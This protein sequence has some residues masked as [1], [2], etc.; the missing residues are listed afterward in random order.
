MFSKL[1]NSFSRAM[2]VG[3]SL[4][5]TLEKT[6][7]IV[8]AFADPEGPFS[9]I[10]LQ[11]TNIL[12]QLNLE[13][14]PRLNTACED[15]SRTATAIQRVFSLL[16]KLLAPL[17]RINDFFYSTWK[18]L[19]TTFTSYFMKYIGNEINE[20]YTIIVQDGFA[21]SALP[22]GIIL[23]HCTLVILKLALPVTL[24]KLFLDN[25]LPLLSVIKGFILGLVPTGPLSQWF[26]HFHEIVRE[27]LEA[28]GPSSFGA[29]TSAPTF[30]DLLT[31]VAS[32]GFVSLMYFAIGVD[33]PGRKNSNPL[34]ALLC[35]A[36]DH[37]SK[38]NSLFLFFK[39]IKTSFGETLMWV[40]EWICDITGFASPLTAT[41]NTV[42]NTEL[43]QWFNEVNRVT[44]PVHKL[45]N[46]AKPDF[47]REASLL[48]DK[49][50]FFE[51]QFVK[52]PI[53]P[54]VAGRF[55]HAVTKLEKL[56]ES[57][58]T[59]KGVGQFR[60]EPF[61][62]QFFGEP[63]CGKTMSMSFFINDLLNRM[64]EP[65]DNRLYSLS[66]KDGYWS[67][68]NHQT[69]V[70]IDDFGQILDSAG[71]NDDVK[72]FIFMK[73]CAPLS[74]NMA[75]V[76]EKG[77]QFSSRY[78]FLTSNFPTPA[79]TSG[80]VEIEA[81]QRR[82]NMLVKVTRDGPI[83]ES[84][85]TPVD[86]IRFTLC[87]SLRPFREV[88]G[89]KSM[90]YSQLLDLVHMRCIDH[91]KKDD[92]MK[93]FA[94]G[95]ENPLEAQVKTQSHEEDISPSQ[96]SEVAEHQLASFQNAFCGCLS[97]TNPFFKGSLPA[98]HFE[99]CDVA[100]KVQFQLW[101]YT[102]LANGIS[103]LDIPYWEERLDHNNRH[104]LMAWMDCFDFDEKK[105][106][107]NLASGTGTIQDCVTCD[108]IDAMMVF[109]R[110]THRAQ[111]AYSLIVRYYKILIL[112]CERK[113]KKSP[114][115]YVKQ[116]VKFIGEKWQELP[117]VVRFVFKLYIAYKGCNLIFSMLGKFL[118]SFGH[119]AVPT[120]VSAGLDYL[121]GQ[122]G[123]GCANISGDEATKKAGSNK[124]TNRFLTAQALELGDEWAQ[125]AIKDP[126]LNDSLIKNLVILRFTNGGIWRGIYVC[127]GWILTVAHA[128]HGACD[129]FVF[130]VIHQHSKTTVALNKASDYYKLIP[131]QD[132]VLIHVGDIDGIKRNIIK[133]FASKSGVMYAPG[134]KG[135]VVKPIFEATKAGSLLTF[136]AEGTL[137]LNGG[138]EAIEYG[139]G[140]F[141]L[142]CAR[143][144]SFQRIG[145]NGDCGSVLMLPAIGNRQPVICGIHCAGAKAEY[146]RKGL[147]ESCASAIYREDLEELL[148]TP[149]LEAQGPCAQLRQLRQVD[150][151]PF[152]IK[153]VALV[154]R[155][156]PELAVNVP[157]KTT[158]RKSEIFE[159]L[160]THLGPHL[161]EP[162]ILTIRD[163]RAA[164]FDPYVKGVEKFN[165]T[166][167]NF[168]NEVAQIV[169]QHM[170][171]SLLANLERISVPGGKPIVRGEHEILNGIPGEKFYDAM[172]MS[173]SCGYPFSLSEFGKNKRGYLDGEP[174][175]YMLHRSRP[176]Y[177][178]FCRMDDEVRAGIVTEM[179]TCECAKDER[180]PL[181][182]IYEKP[183][184]RLFTI[185]PFH[186]NMLV[187]KYFLDFSAS[188]MRAHGTIPCKV[189]INPE[190]FEWTALANSFLE[191]S[192]TGF[193][194]D[195]SSF[196]GRAPVFIF[197]WF[198][199][200]V[201]EYYGDHS[202]S[203][204]SLARHALLQMASCH[205]TLCEDKCYRV[206]GGMPSGFSLTVL[207]NSL[208]N[209]FYMRYAFEMLLRK[210]QNRARTLGMTQ[211]NFEDL[212]VA[213]YGDDNL[214]AV[215]FNMRWYNLPSIAEELLKVN[216]VIK[217]G[218]DKS[219]DVSISEFQPLGELIFLSRGFKR[220]V[221][222]F[223]QAPLKWVSITEPLRWIRPSS[224]AAPIEALVQNAEGS[225]RAAFMHGRTAFEGLRSTI[226]KAFAARQLPV[227]SL[228]LFEEIERNWLAEV[229]GADPE[230][231]ICAME[232]PILQLP[233]SG[234][235]SDEDILRKVNEFVPHVFYCSART[236]KRI[237]LDEY[238]FI[239]CTAS[240]HPKWVRGPATWRDLENKV[241]AYTMGAIEV[242]QARRIAD[243]KSTNL[244][245]VCPGGIGMS[246][247]CCALVT[248]A[249]SQYT[250]GQVVSR[251]RTLTHSE[252]LSKIADGA[253]HYVLLAAQAGVTAEN[254]TNGFLYGSNIYDRCLKIGN[255][256]I[257]VGGT[258]QAAPPN[259]FW[260]TPTSGYASLRTNYNFITK[261]DPRGAKLATTLMHAKRAGDT[262]FL[263]FSV[264]RSVE[265]EWVLSAVRASG[266]DVTDVVS[267]DLVLLER[268]SRMLESGAFG[269]IHIEIKRTFTGSFT[270][271]FVPLGVIQGLNS[272]PLPFDCSAFITPTHLKEKISQLESTTYVTNSLLEAL[273]LILVINGVKS[274]KD[275]EGAVRQFY[276]NREMLA[277]VECKLAMY[278]WFGLPLK[279][280][281][282]L[283]PSGLLA[284]ATSSIKYVT[285]DRTV[286]NFSVDINSFENGIEDLNVS[287]H[288]CYGYSSIAKRHVFRLPFDMDE[289]TFMLL[290][291]TLENRI[292]KVR[293]E[294]LLEYPSWFPVDHSLIS[295]LAYLKLEYI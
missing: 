238:I 154:G 219:Q 287:L 129:G 92:W 73:S 232:S 85:E 20:L 180:L 266:W 183:K 264:F 194:A 225:L 24:G 126:F 196:D 134:S 261:T 229:T 39:N 115:S 203:P 4:L 116:I 290:A 124:K 213:I 144:Y 94:G 11:A 108:D 10:P 150:T 234:R 29:E 146:I 166:A 218:L 273:K 51:A 176:V 7:K 253:G 104:N 152:E 130:S 101:Q 147:K 294:R 291:L 9:E 148:P 237:N 201:D 162:S 1:S 25:I 265:A 70:L 114:L 208:L 257:I 251:L 246:V 138:N 136:A 46:F 215:P 132:L 157:H 81:V 22:L 105:F 86:N 58:H 284:D 198:C 292:R 207:F 247:V 174:G 18:S 68:Y 217:N 87:Y 181:E 88:D 220:H 54:F 168:D 267:T 109:K 15:A 139:D 135:V 240:S 278:L 121:D 118:P 295:S 178:E 250:K 239:N 34:S 263:F 93:Q 78:I 209:E 244:L 37:A 41:V 171:A 259:A 40:G 233:E 38:M 235:P 95:L 279:A 149:K 113:A 167:C 293:K 125:W 216:V 224:D 64:G 42:L 283:V 127:S 16:E 193:S 60:K 23:F 158:L 211:R 151:N 75:A 190:G 243:N 268:Q 272:K 221:T 159:E 160:E 55:S 79:K 96:M 242:E 155:M 165:E 197:Q 90:T 199:D 59:H 254:D 192:Q 184:T 191:V 84:C 230:Q 227:F 172:D 122:K 275:I 107:L 5:D 248:L 204:A 119:S 276:P 80:V 169:M 31:S 286:A 281:S 236:A 123:S 256:C 27:P 97:S 28:Q 195:Y 45:E 83:D 12:S 241:W 270:A 271:H 252:N 91:W 153:Q 120:A 282:S 111:F 141:K 269:R 89:F 30:S 112:Q 231:P 100:I 214:V 205:F 61:C 6:N 110:S 177:E 262:V 206:V 76:E 71:Q 65:K 74:L 185:L 164:S 200:M 131:G 77:T 249:S 285:R 288:E 188:L 245:F 44:D 182:K 128:F 47:G 142:Q 72:D 175:D 2:N 117:P 19:S 163:T 33:K 145:E 69:A 102:L 98:T 161:T 223:F 57:A 99:I 212:F 49:I 17:F 260:V 140:K 67:N 3:P 189:G 258:P 21:Q 36:G 56:L 137:M 32:M 228:P 280:A 179:I 277:A 255:C 289:V 43:F 63:G 133:H 156:P 226:L 50:K 202:D 62:L 14:V 66:S 8:D 48:K 274:E 186:Y 106:A 52:H 173:T 82:R 187:R 170:K 143:A 53:S 222:S 210:P 13:T 103:D 26:S 35:G